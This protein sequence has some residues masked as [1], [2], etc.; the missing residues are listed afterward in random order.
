MAKL[1]GIGGFA[2]GK[3]GDTVF[4]VRN[5]VQIIRQYNPDIKDPDTASQREVRAKFKLMSQLADTYSPLLLFRRKKMV[6]PRNQFIKKNFPLAYYESDTAHLMVQYLQLSDGFRFCPHFEVDR[7][8]GEQI[9]VRL[10]ENA[11]GYLSGVCYSAVTVAQNGNIEVLDS[12]LV[13]DAGVQGQFNGVLQYSDSAIDVYAVGIYNLN[14]NRL[15]ARYGEIEGNAAS[16]LAELMANHPSFL[17]RSAFSITR[18]CC[19]D[20]GQNTATSEQESGVRVTVVAPPG[21]YVSG[22]GVYQ[23]GDEVTIYCE[24][25][26]GWEFD[27][28]YVNNV[29]VSDDDYYT[30]IAVSNITV[31]CR[32][33]EI[34]SVQIVVNPNNA[35]W[36]SVSGGGSFEI[37][38]SCTLVAT[39]NSGY[40]FRGWYDVW[41]GNEST[42]H[43]ISTDNPY[44]F[45]VQDGMFVIGVF[46]MV[47]SISVNVAG[48][49][50]ISGGGNFLP[51][52]TCQLNAFPN[53]GYRFRGWYD[54]WTGTS[55]TSHLLSYDVP[56]SFQV[57]EPASIVGSFSA[58][59]GS[60]YLIEADFG[61]NSEGEA[62]DVEGTGYYNSTQ[63]AIMECLF[64]DGEYRF[65]GWFDDPSKYE[66]QDALSMNPRY[67]F[68]PAYSPSGNLRL[69]YILWNL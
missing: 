30:F 27:G 33:H 45:V 67:S 1:Y 6:S 53:T 51:G 36:G 19:L 63:V 24:M 11:V 61:E 65:G 60:G 55:E 4:A 44:T 58:T 7:S 34:T 17:S 15:Y 12:I 10:L 13:T 38:D 66:E 14:V 69:Y 42:S 37:G 48:R 40:H 43:R 46:D 56:Y 3:K 22:A 8:D 62:L 23:S 21:S 47:V 31:E 50:N 57:Y 49:G 2:T 52:E 32:G 29:L 35:L 68:K 16:F 26:D 54:Q 20:V 18:G 64:D 39:P 25:P 5:G 28:Y 59:Q 9:N 41:T